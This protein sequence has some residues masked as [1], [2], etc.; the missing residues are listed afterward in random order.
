FPDR[1]VPVCNR[2]SCLLTAASPA[3]R[4]G[5]RPPIPFPLLSFAESSHDGTYGQT[6]T[7]HLA[8]GRPRPPRSRLHA[9]HAIARGP[10]RLPPPRWRSSPPERRAPGLIREPP[11]SVP[12]VRR[13]AVS[14]PRIGYSMVTIQ[15]AGG[16][17]RRRQRGHGQPG[18]R[19][20]RRHRHRH[21]RG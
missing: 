15:T 18:Y 13:K 3:H 6:P 20:R 19:A 4:L 9:H 11:L 7:C 1:V 10:E 5:A 12:C 2:E 17:T 8:L 14:G 21:R 16:Y